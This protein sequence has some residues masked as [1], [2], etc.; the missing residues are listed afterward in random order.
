M[1]L[2]AGKDVPSAEKMSEM[3]EE[4]QAAEACMQRAPGRQSMLRKVCS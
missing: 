4:L 3:I 1:Q 2:F